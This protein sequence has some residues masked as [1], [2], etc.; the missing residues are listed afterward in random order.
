MSRSLSRR[1][2]LVKRSPILQSGFVVLRC[3]IDVPCQATIQEYNE[4]TEKYR[5]LYD[6]NQEDEV[7]L[8]KEA[9]KWFGPKGVTAGYTAVMKEI[10]ISLGAE[11][12]HTEKSSIP[13]TRSEDLALLSSPVDIIGRKLFLYW[14]ATGEKYEAEVLAYDGRK[15]LHYLWYRDGELEWVDLKREAFVWGD[16]SRMVK[17]F[18]A[19]LEEGK[20]PSSFALRFV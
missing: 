11:N 20:R 6:D 5:L 7:D 2:F 12:I 15:K 18:P 9:F 1:R 13:K 4:G 16:D 17:E 8:E 10:M 3:L 14:E 19:G